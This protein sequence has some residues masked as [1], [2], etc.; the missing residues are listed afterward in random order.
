[1]HHIHVGS[2]SMRMQDSRIIKH[3]KIARW[4]SNVLSILENRSIYHYF[5]QLLWHGTSAKNVM[6]ILTWGVKISTDTYSS[7]Y[8]CFTDMV[9]FVWYLGVNRIDLSEKIGSASDEKLS[10]LCEGLLWNLFM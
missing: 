2:Y 1:M 8:I 4:V 9:G 3:A 7:Q 10:G 5:L 6:D